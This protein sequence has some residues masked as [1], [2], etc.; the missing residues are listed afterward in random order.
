MLTSSDRSELYRSLARLLDA[1]L[2]VSA[3]FASLSSA[4]PTRDRGR[5]IRALELVMREGNPLS[6]A[7]ASVDPSD[8]PRH[9]ALTIRG[10]ERSGRVAPA[11]VHLADAEDRQRAT[12][13]TLVQ[14]AFYPVALLHMAVFAPNAGALILDPF[15]TLTR[16]LAIL[17]PLD[18]VLLWVYRALRAPLR[19]PRAA[20]RMLALPLAGPVLVAGAYRRYF[21]TLRS[22]YEAGVPIATAAREAAA[23]VPPGRLHDDILAALAPLD[24]NEPFSHSAVR[25]PRLNADLRGLIVTSEPAGELGHA[26]EQ[27]TNICAETETS[28]Q[29]RLARVVGGLMFALAACYVAYRVIGFYAAYFAQFSR[30]SR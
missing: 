13:S 27:V 25:F 30:L 24:Q 3:V 6:D 5:V 2:S 4:Y 20:D 10:A 9:H 16:L 12:M 26:F 22:M 23:A 15:G 11:L 21:D 19:H 7:M 18:L 14:K 1:G 17:I 29:V 28:G 8:V